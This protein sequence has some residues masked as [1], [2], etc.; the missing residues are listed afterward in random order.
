LDESALGLRAMMAQMKQASPP[1]PFFHK[2]DTDRERRELD[3]ADMVALSGMFRRWAVRDDGL[4]PE[5]RTD[6]IMYSADY[7]RLAEWVGPNWRASEPSEAV[8][9][10]KFMATIE[11]KTD[12]VT[13]LGEV[14]RALSAS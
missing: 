3:Y 11:R 10:T 1:R 6:F 5:D 12:N 8:P 4:S 9:L 14:R 2:L 7:E 13:D